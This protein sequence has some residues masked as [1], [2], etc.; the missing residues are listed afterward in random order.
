MSLLEETRQN[1]PIESDLSRSTTLRF[2]AFDVVVGSFISLCLF[3]GSLACVTM[4]WVVAIAV[5]G[6]AGGGPSTDTTVTSVQTDLWGAGAMAA[7]IFLFALFCVVIVTGLT[8]VVFG[9]IAGLLSLALRRVTAWPLHL[10]AYFVLGIVATYCVLLISLHTADLTS[11][12][13][14]PFADALALLAGASAAGGWTIA[15]RLAIQRDRQGS[16]LRALFSAN[17]DRP[18]F[19]DE[20]FESAD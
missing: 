18:P 16:Q 15:W 2:S 14:N 1:A 13:G 12:V 11:V 19:R 9:P 10:V 6:F 4:W 8:L 3:A 7:V 20:R 5:Y 17:V